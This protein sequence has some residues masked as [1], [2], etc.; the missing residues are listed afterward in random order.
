MRVGLDF[1]P[2]LQNREGIGRYARELVRSFVELG[3][4]RDVALFGSTL[5]QSRFSTDELGYGRARLVRRRL[6]A[7]LLPTLLRASGRGADDSL[8]GVD[9]WHHTQPNVLPVRRAREV[10][11][12]FDT[13]YLERDGRF[14]EP[15]TAERM[16]RA[17]RALVERSSLLF[18]PTQFVAREVERAFGVARERIA[19]TPLGCDHVLR[20]V[21]PEGFA[22]A[23]GRFV[24]TASR[25]DPRKNHLRMLAAFERLVRD[26]FPHRWLVVGPHGWRTEAFL[27]AVEASPARERI[28]VREFV[29]DAELARLM[30]QCE[31]FFFASLSEGFGLPPL[32]AMLLGAPTIASSATTLPEV[33]GDGALLPDPEDVDALHA[34][35][36]SV[37]SDPEFARALAARGRTHAAEWTWLRCSRA[38]WS[39]YAIACGAR[40]EA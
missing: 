40:L 5:A 9:V 38:T 23:S 36:K 28:E 14:V 27:R 8:G 6:P 29:D 24:L 35:A 34:A 37:L 11:T 21:P 19:V 32:E 39:A 10:A 16:S 33:C 20:H 2:G 7:K 3:H 18:V 26:G 4:D 17:A 15:E 13:I 25:I 12:I 30:A 22:P 1:R 31:L